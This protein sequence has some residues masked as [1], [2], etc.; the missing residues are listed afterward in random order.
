MFTGGLLRSDKGEWLSGFSTKEGEGDP[1]LAELLA[2]KN[3]LAHAWEEGAKHVWCESDSSE[4]ISVLSS[5]RDYAL[6]AH[7]VTILEI[8]KFIN[9]DWTVH[10][11][12]VL[13]EAN[14]C[15][16]FLAT[17]ANQMSTVWQKWEDPPILMGSLLLRDSLTCGS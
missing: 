4:V 7:A 13:R 11:H 10:L 1:F 15:A 8:S 14:T 9:R 16:D 3:G 17:T 6:H 2:V 5:A 12:H